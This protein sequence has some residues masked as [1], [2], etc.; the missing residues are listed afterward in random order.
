MFLWMCSVLFHV[1]RGNLRITLLTVYNFKNRP[2]TNKIL[3]QIITLKDTVKN[4]LG[5][6]WK[7]VCEL[8]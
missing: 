4:K 7:N 6:V 2:Y 5:K 8:F 1:V 3:V